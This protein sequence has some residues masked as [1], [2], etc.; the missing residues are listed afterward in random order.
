MRTISQEEYKKLYGEDSLSAFKNIPKPEESRENFFQ[1]VATQAKTGANKVK[2]GIEQAAPLKKDANVQDLVLGGLKAGAGAAQTVFS[3]ATAAVEPVTKPTIGKAID[4]TADKIS[5]NES[6]QKFAGSE[7]G[8]ETEKIVGGVSD[9]NEI[10]GAFVGPKGAKSAGE[11]VANV[12]DN[13]TGKILDK[14]GDLMTPA[15]KTETELQSAFVK[16]ATP[17]Y[18][19][20]LIGDR[21]IENADGT[22][23]QRVTEGSTLGERT[24]N[25]TKLETE[26]GNALKTVENYPVN[27]TSLEKYQA[28]QP[29]ISAQSSTLMK[30]LEA[31]KI[32]RPP[33]EVSNIVKTAIKDRAE[34]SL[35]LQKTDPVIKNY[36]RVLQNA[37]DAND[38][39]LA[40]ELKVRQAMDAAYKNA[41]G[42]AAFGSDRVSAL[43]EIHKAGRDALNEDIISKAKNTDV[44][45]ALK[46]QWDLM[47]ASDVLLEKAESEAQSGIGRLEQKFPKTAKAAKSLLNFAGIGKGVNLLAP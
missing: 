23:T 45:A 3:P 40:G 18:S 6:V 37:I 32:L 24:V 41:R 12:V 25:P 17:A 30:G 22:V 36:I 2:A 29:S 34:N 10:L 4:Y 39:T 21:A 7:M 47:R 14:A 31:E 35:L 38:G 16:D 27:G 19:K 28:V 1:R 33:K 8:K 13:A 20:K 26:A 42:N 46:S 11:G 9:A 5:D 44:K 43:D 15:V